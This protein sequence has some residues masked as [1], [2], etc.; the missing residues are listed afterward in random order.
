MSKLSF[1]I[2]L[3]L[4]SFVF[5]ILSSLHL[6]HSYEYQMFLYSSF[7]IIIIIQ[8]LMCDLSFCVKV[9]VKNI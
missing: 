6:V 5:D 8:E 7:I 9:C 2:F 3:F 1:I 4:I